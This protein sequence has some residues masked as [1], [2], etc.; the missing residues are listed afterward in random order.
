MSKNLVITL[1]GR[2]EIGIVDKVTN[3]ILKYHG[4]IIESKMARLGGEFV[5]LLQVDVAKN[6][7]KL[8][9]E[10]ITQFEDQGYKVFYKETVVDTRDKFNGWLPYEIIVTGADHEGIINQV[11]HQL[12]KNGMNVESIDTKISS[13]PMSGTALFSM[14]AVVMAP[15]KKTIQTWAEELDEVATEMNVD[16]DIFNYRG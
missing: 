5:M 14:N 8:L 15:P 4:N 12:A 13:A 2:D 9:E 10:T 3:I 11:T 6:D 7:L 1:I 16:I